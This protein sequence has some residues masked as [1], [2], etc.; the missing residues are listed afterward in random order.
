M[1]RVAG[2]S[3]AALLSLGFAPAVA[4]DF[5]GS[6]NLICAPVQAM[7]C[8]AGTECIAGTPDDIA[9][10]AFIRLDFG[11][12]AIVGPKRTTAIR[13]LEKSEAQLLLQGTEEK[14]GWTLALDQASG[15]MTITIAHAEGAFVL[16]GNCTPQ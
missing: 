1:K 10:P 2:W 14:F 5:D 3:A 11:K 8:L 12:K 15:G 9:F 6:K 13:T 7:D 16:F 4:G